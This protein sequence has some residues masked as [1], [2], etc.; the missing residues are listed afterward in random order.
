MDKSAP[1]FP[2]L[3][4]FEKYLSMM[5][6]ESDRGCVLIAAA[7][8]DELLRKTLKAFMVDEKFVEDNLIGEARALGTFSSRNLACRALGI[9][10]K[11]EFHDIDKIRRIRNEFAH[12]I[13]ASFDDDVI[14]V[15]CDS[16]IYK[17]K[18]FKDEDGSENWVSSAL[19]FRTSATAIILRLFMR[20]QQVSE[21]RCSPREWINLDMPEPLEAFGTK[22]HKLAP[23]HPKTRKEPP[24]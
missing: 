22:I 12:E 18:D 16:L 11:E 10:N 2:D 15:Y 3:S 8:I 6:G 21:N 19:Q 4:E 7:N 20:P 24:K 13:D 17:K 9:I 14:A 5:N 23:G 1:E